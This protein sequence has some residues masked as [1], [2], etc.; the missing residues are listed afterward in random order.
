MISKLERRPLR[1]SCGEIATYVVS[2][3]ELDDNILLCD[4]HA[5]P[6]LEIEKEYPDVKN[7]S[8]HEV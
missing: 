8:L 5:K 7:K 6:Y 3:K 4:E 2:H 1:C